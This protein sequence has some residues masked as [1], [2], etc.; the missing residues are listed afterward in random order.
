MKKILGGSMVVVLG[1]IGMLAAKTPTTPTGTSEL[2]LS[3]AEALADGEF[4]DGCRWSRVFD[5]KGC[6]FH[7]CVANGSGD[8]CTCGDVDD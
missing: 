8:V 6:V 4:T 1:V 7:V 2:E 5:K 3:N